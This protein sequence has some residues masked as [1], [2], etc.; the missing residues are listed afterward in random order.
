MQPKDILGH[1]NFF[2]L[3]IITPVVQEFIFVEGDTEIS[4]VNCKSSPLLPPHFHFPSQNEA[5]CAFS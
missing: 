2:H 5:S 4:R 1:P 3:K